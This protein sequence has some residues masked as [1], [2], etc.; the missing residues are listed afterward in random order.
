[1]YVCMYE[2]ICMYSKMTYSLFWM[3]N[4]WHWFEA[5]SNPGRCEMLT[6]AIR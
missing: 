4:L 3:K 2:C 5:D 6:G 1:M